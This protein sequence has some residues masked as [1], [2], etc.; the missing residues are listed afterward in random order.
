MSEQFFFLS[1][2]N[3]KKLLPSNTYLDFTTILPKN[4]ILPS[5]GEDGSTI[6]WVVAITDFSIK[7][8]EVE[9]REDRC[10][11]CGKS[12]SVKINIEDQ[13]YA[14]LCDLAEESF[15][16][17]A[18]LPVLRIFREGSFPSSSL[19]VPYYMPVRTNSFS[20]IRIYILG[21]D[22]NS[23]QSK[24]VKAEN[25]DASCTLHLVPLKG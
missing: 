5:H 23:I 25:I 15:I 19:G 10:I 11:L 9:E 13:S 4:V 16:N 2:K 1:S 3:S 24:G 21:E 20:T 17:G 7:V 14:V 12:R 22:T 18:Q 8:G 6:R